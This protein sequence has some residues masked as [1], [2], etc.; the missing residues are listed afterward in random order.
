MNEKVKRRILWFY[1]GGVINGV[2]GIYVLISGTTFLPA[3]TAQMLMAVFFLFAAVDFYMPYAIKKKWL[4][5]QAA[6]A[7]GSGEPPA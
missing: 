3:D 4:E 5:D 6:R 1:I 7:Q 2:L